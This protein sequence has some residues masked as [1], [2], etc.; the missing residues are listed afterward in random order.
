MKTLLVKVLIQ[1]PAQ[2]GLEQLHRVQLG[3]IVAVVLI[4]HQLRLLLPQRFALTL[5][6]CGS[7]A[8]WGR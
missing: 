7:P 5:H 3:S 8:A 1:S 2:A 6:C 4:T